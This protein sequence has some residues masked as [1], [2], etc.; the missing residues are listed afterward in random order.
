[1]IIDIDEES[2][3]PIEANDSPQHKRQKVEKRGMKRKASSSEPCS[4]GDS[5]ETRPGLEQ[6]HDWNDQFGFRVERAGKVQYEWL[7]ERINVANAL[8]FLI[9]QRHIS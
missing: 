2:C 8:L 4:T 7:K 3:S 9:P 1:M 6:G 5:Q